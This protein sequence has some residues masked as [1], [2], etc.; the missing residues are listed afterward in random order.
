M[1]ANNPCIPFVTPPPP[2]LTTP[3]NPWTIEAG[4]RQPSLRSW[5][6]ATNPLP[7]RHR[8][9]PGGAAGRLGVER[10]L[11]MGEGPCGPG[12]SVADV[13]GCRR[14]EGV[15]RVVRRGRPRWG[16]CFVRPRQRWR[17]G[18]L[19]WGGHVQGTREVRFSLFYCHVRQEGL[20]G[21]LGERKPFCV[22]T[23]RSSGES[24]FRL[25]RTVSSFS[26]VHLRSPIC[27]ISS[28]REL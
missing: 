4:G 2:P 8:A 20:V 12:P 22:T 18:W 1:V 10:V 11:R 7:A 21:G 23:D 27:R 17:W 26:R 25:V 5:A 6:H 14:R 15:R 9:V 13:G 28:A 16:G 24:P 3:L 19:L